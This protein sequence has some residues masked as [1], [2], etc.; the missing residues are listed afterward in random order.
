MYSNPS[1]PKSVDNL[2]PAVPPSAHRTNLPFHRQG[3]TAS[4]IG[5]SPDTTSGSQENAVPETRQNAISILLQPPI[6]QTGPIPHTLASPSSAHKPPTT[7]D[8]PP[9]T[10]TTTTHV[11]A[12]EI[13]PYL[14]RVGVLYNQLRRVK[15]SEDTAADNLHGR[16]SKTDKFA[17]VF[18]DS[19]LQPGKR[20]LVLRKGSV[21]SVSLFP[22]T[23][24][25]SPIRRP[26][27]R[28]M[29][30]PPPLSTIP[31]VFFD[32]DFHLENPRTFDIVSE[33]SEVIQLPPGIL[34]GKASANGNAAAPRKAL[35]INAI[36]QEKLSWYIDTIEI[37]LIDSISTA[38]TAFFTALRSLRELYS[39][40]AGS[41]ER[42]KALKKELEALDNEI[43]TSGLNIIQKRQR[44]ENLQQLHNTVLQLKHVVD[45]VAT[46]ESFV[47]NGEVDQALESID[48]LE[49]L[50]AGEPELSKTPLNMDGWHLQLRDLRAATALQSVNDD[51]S[52]LRSR[53]GKV[54]E[55]RFLGLLM[56]DLRRH[57][58][59]VSTQE[60]LMRWTSASVR[61]RGVYTQE[62][63][64]FPSYMSLT[65]RVRSELRESLTGLHRAQHLTTAATAYREAIL[66]EIRNL[67]RRPLPSSH[68]DDKGSLMSSSTMPTRLSQQEKS[69][70]LAHNLQALEPEEAEELLI[71]IYISVTE[72][73]RR[74]TTQVKL[75]LDFA[76]SLGH[77][78]SPSGLTSPQ[79]ESPLISPTVKR[80]SIAALDAQELH[81]AMDL[82]NLLGQA[83]DVAQDKVIRILRVRLEQSAHPSL[84]WFL[85]YFTLTVYFT[86]ECESISGR[87]GT[88]LK[89][90]VNGQIKDFIHKYGDAEKRKL[91]QGMEYDQW[92]AK[93]F[94][95]KDTAELNRILSC[96]TK[97]P[98]E[99]SGGLKIWIPYSDDHLETNGAGEPQQPNS[100]GK[101]RT[102]NA[103]IN[104]EIFMLPNSAILCMDG[105]AHFLQLIV[106]IP[107]MTP[108]IGASLVSYLQLF[109][110]RCTQLILGAGAR[111]SAGLKN[112][113]SKHLVLAS[114]ALAFVATLIS[115]VREFVRRHTRS[116]G[117]AASSLVEFDK[118][119]CDYQEHENSIYNKIVEIM[120]R[121]AAAHVKAMKNI[122]WD[123]G[124][125]NV[126][127]YM[128]ILAKDTTSLHRILTKTLP[129]GTVRMLMTS[130]FISYKD[131]FGKAFQGVDPKTELGLG[132]MLHDMDFFKSKLGK[133][134]GFGDTGEYLAAIIKS[135]QVK[136]VGLAALA[137][138]ELETKDTQDTEDL[139]ETRDR[140]EDGTKGGRGG[141]D[142]DSA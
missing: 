42:I 140:S 92:E 138:T 40:A 48:S 67:I 22:P 60:V 34:D 37:C 141:D 23:E 16:R 99:W 109:N 98:A 26:G 96:S 64:V 132:S 20:P 53:I 123:N 38:S 50:I 112:I 115:H 80:S 57:L 24:A 116:G 119:K 68:D 54:Y 47:D 63:S 65:D 135:K 117:A 17:A 31:S 125:K 83:V 97:D 77:D 131:Q 133:I 55:T 137:A 88:A 105:L 142:K 107:S 14:S 1:A 101:A 74:L 113:T 136:G 130:V 100:D 5:A 35:A 45:G 103:S 46:C 39:E 75:L 8:I 126:H 32:K 91:A 76:S 51:L 58:E 129:E 36:L 6:V 128:G 95:E 120:S 87:S 73:L 85:R 29:R 122:D 49:K 134:D 13:Q 70:I 9:V 28:A 69:S 114:R 90:V 102:R 12:A 127:P 79:R 33:R 93:D 94:S 72:T 41:V 66:K 82:Q 25:P 21:S 61:S 56:G 81:E 18:D 11:D 2:S 7:R 124:Q 111:L 78:S 84:I 139:A 27:T 44:Q 52:T 19:H 15:E 71:K 10:L 110:S 59:A 121:L 104:E 4:S 106:A 86:N 43:A 108:D 3:S 89:S 30:D 62:S 118:V